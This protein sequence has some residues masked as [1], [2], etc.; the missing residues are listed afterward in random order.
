MRY[1]LP[2]LL[3][4]AA[5]LAAQN[6]GTFG[7][8]MLETGSGEPINAGPCEAKP[9]RCNPESCDIVF[10]WQSDDFDTV[11]TTS[12][13]QGFPS[14]A[15]AMNGQSANQ[16][17]GLRD[18]DPRDCIYNDVSDSVFCFMSDVDAHMIA[19]DG[20]AAWDE[21][22]A[23]AG[24]HPQVSGKQPKNPGSADPQMTDLLAPL[25]GLYRLN[26]TWDCETLGSDG[27]AVAI[28][29]DVFIGVE[30]RC[31]LGNGRAVG[32]YGAAIF[33]VQ[34]E[35]EGTTWDDE[36]ILRRDEWGGLAMITADS[37]GLMI[38]CD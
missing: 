30:S 17:V 11:I 25:Q 33:D 10:H 20:V 7:A 23:L 3:G 21:L 26:A 14:D 12:S 28:A 29:G 9:A 35:G 36:Y 8:C 16:P 19:V 1:I 15:Y 13:A 18:Q 5:P 4:T 2:I 32:S 22:M 24:A 31:Q 38:A 34:C 27:G 6:V 37:V